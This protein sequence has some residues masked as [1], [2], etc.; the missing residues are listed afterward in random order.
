MLKTFRKIGLGVWALA[1]VLIYFTTEIVADEL[2]WTE[3]VK[4]FVKEGPKAMLEA[5]YDAWLLAIFWILTGGLLVAWG[6]Y[7]LR[8][9]ERKN[10]LENWV[11]F[12]LTVTTGFYDAKKHTGISEVTILDGP[13]LGG[14]FKSDPKISKNSISLIFQFENEIA[15]PILYVTSDRKIIWRE[16]KSSNYYMIVDIDLS[17]KDNIALSVMIRP[18]EWLGAKKKQDSLRWHDSTVF[19]REKVLRFRDEA[20]L[21]QLPL[22][23]ELGKQP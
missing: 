14:I 8:K 19:P 10:R 22:G 5:G 2:G 16:V 23:I 12:S 6:E 18:R 20:R 15:E 3:F 17:Y 11:N 1:L 7:A 21:S 13:V 9:F 4:N